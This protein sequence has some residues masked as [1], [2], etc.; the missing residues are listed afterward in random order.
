MSRPMTSEGRTAVTESLAVH[1][2]SETGFAG[3]KLLLPGA[4][5][6]RS[7][8][9]P[10]AGILAATVALFSASAVLAP[11]SLSASSLAPMLPFWAVLAVVSVGQTLVDRTT[12]GVGKGG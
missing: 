4:R 10:R 11:S 1:G 7:I 8:L 12:A 9:G 6:R 5:V 2:D 3:G